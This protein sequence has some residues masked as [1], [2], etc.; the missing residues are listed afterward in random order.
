MKIS[1]HYDK[2]T[3][4]SL[5]AEKFQND[6]LIEVPDKCTV[7]DLIV[8]LETPRN[9]REALTVHVNNEPV[10]NSTILKEGDSVKL[11]ISIGGG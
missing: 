7:R 4:K 5:N 6:S 1:L 10:W 3:G 2:L 9:R 11:L 8:L